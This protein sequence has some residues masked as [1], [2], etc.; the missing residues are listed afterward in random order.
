MRTRVTCTILAV[1]WLFASGGARAGG[2]PPKLAFESDRLTY[3]V[4][5]QMLDSPRRDQQLTVFE[6]LSISTRNGL[7][8]PSDQWAAN[9]FEV[10]I[11]ALDDNSNSPAAVPLRTVDRTIG[12]RPCSSY[13]SIVFWVPRLDAQPQIVTTFDKDW[14]ALPGGILAHRRYLLVVEQ[15]PAHAEK[16]VSGRWQ[17]I[18]LEDQS[19]K[20]YFTRGIPFTVAPTGGEGAAAPEAEKAARQAAAM[21]Q[22][23]LD[24]PP[25]RTFCHTVTLARVGRGPEELAYLDRCTAPWSPAEGATATTARSG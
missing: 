8:P 15:A 22:T 19:A 20:D 12:G 18:R 3:V 16:T 10:R 7:P 23:E 11:F 6:S 1:I 13:L 5:G 4:A 25:A 14:L 24:K 21:L 2:A 9:G 17:I